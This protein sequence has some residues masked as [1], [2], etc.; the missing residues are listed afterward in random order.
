VLGH[1]LELVVEDDETTDPGVVLAFS[2]LAT[3]AELVAFLGSIKSTEVHAMA[4]DVLKFG[5][6]V[7]IDGT[8]PVLTHMGNPWFF[9]FRPN[10]G[11]RRASLQTTV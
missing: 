2:K 5:K 6:P 3:N 7:L 8:D 4:P 10:D 1:Q 11:I 9:R